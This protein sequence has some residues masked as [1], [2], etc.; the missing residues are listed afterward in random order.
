M[1]RLL[2]KLRNAQKAVREDIF[3]RPPTTFEAFVRQ[4][5][6]HDGLGRAAEMIEREIAD[7]DEAEKRN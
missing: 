3:D 1:E 7:D 6:I 5:G 2:V 4:W